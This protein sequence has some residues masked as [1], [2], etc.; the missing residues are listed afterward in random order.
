MNRNVVI[1]L[2]GGFLIA[3]LVAMI[4]QASLGKKKGGDMVDIA[5]ASRALNAG[6]DLKEADMKWQSFPKAAVF[7]GAISRAGDQK[8]TDVVKGRLRRDIG[9]GEPILRN[10]VVSEARGNI[11]TATMDPGMRAMAVKV[12]ADMMVGGFINPGDRVDVVL[13]HQIRIT[14]NAAKEAVA[15]TVSRY[16]SEI[17]LENIKVLAID[18]VARK[19]DDKA[20]VG[21]TVTLEV[22]PAGSE[23]LALALSMGKISL[24]LRS[25]A[26]TEADSKDQKN[27]TAAITLP[28]KLTT[29]VSLSRALQTVNEIKKNTSENRDIMRVYTGD[30]VQ[31]ISVRR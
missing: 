19:E 6:T 25:L 27:K 17:I 30:T 3:L 29:D 18:Q 22:D 21:K 4:V 14:G 12:S 13:T 26:A 28:H 23:K 16:V 15:D 24:A 1:V 7:P 2:A 9:A 20:K 10:V 31:N 11:L 5:V 8:I